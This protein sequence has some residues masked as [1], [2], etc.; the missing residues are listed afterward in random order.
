MFPNVLLGTNRFFVSWS[1]APD[2]IEVAV[3]SQEHGAVHDRRG[4]YQWPLN[5]V[6]GEFFE[7]LA[8]FDHCRL[9]VVAEEI[10]A[11]LGKEQGGE[12]KATQALLPIN[13]PGRR[14]RA[15]SHA[16]VGNPIKL[17]AAKHGGGHYRNLAR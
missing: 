9:S 14:L 17:I 10:H 3:R 15:G 8:G 5:L 6:V 12:M 7:P 13:L 4:S 11:T 2:P 1:V 16:F